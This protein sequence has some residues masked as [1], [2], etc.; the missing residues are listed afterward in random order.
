MKTSTDITCLRRLL[1][2]DSSRLIS[3][4]AQLRN[5]L[6]DWM[7]REQ[8][9]LFKAIMDRYLDMTERHIRDL[10][11]F[12]KEEQLNSVKV[13][14]LVIK[15]LMDELNE[16]L[17][18]CTCNEVKDACLLAGIQAINHYKISAYGTA[19]AYASALRLGKAALVFHQAEQD[20]KIIDKELSHLATHEINIRALA[21]VLTAD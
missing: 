17:A 6:G 5:S 15:A 9:P 21:P 19:V 11:Q 20:E 1:D 16:K 7:S 12:C 10:E 8:S 3:G 2:E 4:E 18:S 14:N 13:S